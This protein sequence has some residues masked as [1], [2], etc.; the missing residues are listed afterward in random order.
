MGAAWIDADDLDAI[1]ECLYVWRNKQQAASALRVRIAALK[2]RCPSQMAR[3]APH[4]H[5]LASLTG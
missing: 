2:E 4:M 5:S 3:A 1:I